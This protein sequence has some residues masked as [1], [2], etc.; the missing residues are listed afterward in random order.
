MIAIDEAHTLAIEA[1][2]DILHVVQRL[3]YKE[4]PVVLLLAGTP[5]L[6]RHLN[7][8]EA[9]FWDRSEILPLG[10]L[11]PEAAA[12]AIRTPMEAEGR[13]IS[14]EAL[15][16]VVAESHGYPFFLQ[17][18]GRLLWTGMS[19]AALPAS[20][21]DVDRA[22]PLFQKARNRY[23]RNRHAE[24]RR[25]KLAFVAAKLSLAFMDTDELT[26]LEVDEAIRLALET[27]GRTA[28]TDA[29]MAACDRLH[30]LGYIWSAGDET[31]PRFLPGI[32]SLMQYMARSR[33]L[34]VGPDAV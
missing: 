20:L 18:W 10:L 7:S 3:R 22:S 13:A 29:V 12:S 17:L 9:S 8:M 5:D 11:E 28:D 32:P 31:R 2:Q 1:G 6:P 27:E 19:D 16:R 4:Q 25:A 14:D 15:T 30:D 33:D 23:Y 26:D 21:G 24:L 34:D